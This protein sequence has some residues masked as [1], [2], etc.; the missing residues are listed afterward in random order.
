MLYGVVHDL[1]S[2]PKAV[3]R[4]LQFGVLKMTTLADIPSCEGLFKS[5]LNSD[6]S[7][8]AQ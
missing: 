4:L 2:S 7:Q 1:V 6:P 5:K 8:A 3:H